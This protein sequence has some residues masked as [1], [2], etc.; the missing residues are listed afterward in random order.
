MIELENA[1]FADICTSMT[2]AVE[3][4][5]SIKKR[6]NAVVS[7]HVD[8]EEFILD[9]RSQNAEKNVTTT[10]K[11]D[12]VVKTSVQ[13]LRDLLAKKITSQQAFM[14]GKL[15]IKGK[16]ALAMKLEKILSATRKHLSHSKSRI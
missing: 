7:F 2:N 11:P 6:F 4:D 8:G 9:A 16:M 14:K 1:S 13:T 3:T 10:S 15:K 12:L 5:P